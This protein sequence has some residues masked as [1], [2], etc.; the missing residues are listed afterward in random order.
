MGDTIKLQ[1]GEKLEILETEQDSF[2]EVNVR[3]EGDV[4]TTSK[5]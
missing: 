4:E 2:I 5:D 3:G 1:L